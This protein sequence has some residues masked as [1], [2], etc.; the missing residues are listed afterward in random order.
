MRSDCSSDSITASSGKA[1]LGFETLSPTG[2]ML[3]AEEGGLKPSGG[4][5]DAHG[6]RDQESSLEAVK[7]DVRRPATLS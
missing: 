6:C 5:V 3:T 2:W 1:G 7:W 4:G